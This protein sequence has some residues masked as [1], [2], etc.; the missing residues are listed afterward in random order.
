MIDCKTCK[1]WDIFEWDAVIWHR[2]TDGF[3]DE[4]TS[5]HVET[6]SKGLSSMDNGITMSSQI[7]QCHKY[8]PNK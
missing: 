1:H 4:V 7:K 2:L 8:E 3:I 5:E 6:C